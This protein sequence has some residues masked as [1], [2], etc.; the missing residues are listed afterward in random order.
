M[1]QRKG[2]LASLFDFSFS[3]FIT[4]KIIKILYGIGIFFAG[5]MALFVIVAAFRE[6]PG[7]GILGLLI[8]APLVFLLHVIIA[9]VWLEVIIVIFR[10]AEYARD[11]AAQGQ[12][13]S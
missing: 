4:T 10:I 8:L 12:R 2:F 6:S 1:E 11:I 13:E 9:R 3:E 7:Y 5:L